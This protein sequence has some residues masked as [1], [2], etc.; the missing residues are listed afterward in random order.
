MTEI[1]I[2]TGLGTRYLAL[3]VLRGMTIAFMIIVNTPGSWGSL[4]GP[5]AH[6]DW[7]GFTPTDLVF[8][9][10]L[11]VVGNAMSFS[12]KKLNEMP[13]AQFYRKVLKR[14]ALIFIIGWLLNAFPFFDYQEAGGIQF[15]DL[16]QVRLFGV[17]QRIALAYFFAALIVYWGGERWGWIFSAVGLIGYWALMFI[18]GEA[19]DP[20]SLTGNAA[21]KLDLLLIG[22]DR[23]YTGEGIPFDP[24]GILSTLPSIVNVLAG[25]GIGTLIQR[26]GNTIKTVQLLLISGLILIAC[27]YLWDLA[28][29]INKKIWTSSYVLLTVGWDLILLSALVGII[30]IWKKNQ[31]TYF[32]QVF[33]R[34]PLILYVLS[35]IVISISFLIPIGEISL[36]EYLY[37][38]MFT[39][40]LGPKNASFLFAVSYMLLIWLMGYWMDKQ[41]I[42][43]KV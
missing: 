37:S 13:S 26:K 24:E 2:K 1:P 14:T 39:S 5:L 8:P 41:K 30:E 35:G 21:I 7:H 17:L 38:T 23:M 29:P 42:Y 40:W 36:K 31:W 20:Y 15:I 27:S 3:D 4:Y 32:F 22:E 25:F 43:I 16:T 33:G 11:F 19:G 6:A 10:F 12:M 28:F 34:N 18:F 9:T